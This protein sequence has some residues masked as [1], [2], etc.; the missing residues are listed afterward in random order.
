MPSPVVR[1]NRA[2]ALA[3]AHC[4]PAAQNELDALADALA[5]YQPFHAARA[6]LA[7]RVNDWETAIAE[8]E[9]AIEMAKSSA[10][11]DWLTSKKA[12]ALS[13]LK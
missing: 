7:R 6:E 2:V 13:E 1:L 12:A 9:K 11:R 5:D 4:L 8:Y 10:D 3:E